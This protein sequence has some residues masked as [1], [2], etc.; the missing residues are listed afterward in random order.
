MSKSTAWKT[1]YSDKRAATAEEIFSFFPKEIKPELRHYLENG[2]PIFLPE[3]TKKE[4]QLMNALA[5]HRLDFSQKMLTA[6]FLYG[7]IEGRHF[8][9]N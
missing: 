9:E 7:F 1:P 3:W 5:W 6:V 2:L 4:L 8:E